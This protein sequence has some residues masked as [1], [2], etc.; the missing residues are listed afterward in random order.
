ME[1]DPK[2]KEMKKIIKEYYEQVEM[3]IFLETYPT[4]IDS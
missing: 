2:D 3:D 4:K 1:K